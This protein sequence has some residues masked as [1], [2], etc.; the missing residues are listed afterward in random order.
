VRR[1][2][3]A[4]LLFAVAGSVA[5]ASA[6]PADLGRYA[7]WSRSAQAYFM[8]QAEREQWSTVSTEAE[9]EAFI[10]SFLDKRAKGFGAEVEKRVEQADKFLTVGKT[11]GSDT[12]RGKLLI[13]LG[14]PANMTIQ[15]PPKRAI[16]GAD[17]TA[18]AR[19]GNAAADTSTKIYVMTFNRQTTPSLSQDR[20]D[21]AVE[22]SAASGKDRIRDPRMEQRLADVFEAAARASIVE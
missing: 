5:P 7:H 6:A 19:G 3:I 21:V 20:L 4:A 1:A 11:Q 15:E 10:A 17:P 12:L 18:I 13:L 14:S 16:T 8:T 9:A 22:V 2:F